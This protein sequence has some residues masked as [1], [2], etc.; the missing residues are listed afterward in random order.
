MSTNVLSHLARG[1]VEGVEQGEGGVGGPAIG[2]PGTPDE[3]PVTVVGVPVADGPL[4]DEPVGVPGGEAGEDRL[5]DLVPVAGDELGLGRE[6]DALGQAH[7]LAVDRH[8]LVLGAG[9]DLIG[10]PRARAALTVGASAAGKARA[11]ASTRR[12]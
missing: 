4:A 8:A 7:L 11:A 10:P 3:E 5:H 6:G 9:D 1:P 2:R 12:S